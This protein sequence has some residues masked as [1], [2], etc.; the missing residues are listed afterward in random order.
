MSKSGAGTGRPHRLAAEVDAITGPDR[1]CARRD[2][3][4]TSRGAAALHRSLPGGERAHALHCRGGPVGRPWANRRRRASSPTCSAV[5]GYA[6]GG[7]QGDP[8]SSFLLQPGRLEERGL[9]QPA[10]DSPVLRPSRP[11]RF[12]AV[13]SGSE[14]SGASA[15]TR[16][17]LS[18]PDRHVTVGARH[19][20]AGGLS[21]LQP[22]RDRDR[23]LGA[24]GERLHRLL[25]LYVDADPDDTST[26][27]IWTGSSPSST[28]FT[29][30]GSYFRRCAGSPTTWPLAGANGSGRASTWSACAR[31][32]PPPGGRPPNS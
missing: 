29:Q 30:P 8:P 13:K 9:A 17:T 7:P 27:G 5:S 20:R 12:V 10:R 32:S 4:A 6:Q 25:D 11:A 14:A 16:S 21:V 15:P 18:S 23:G 31:T 22:L 3:I 24:G 19:S 26:A 1:Y 2:Y 28:A